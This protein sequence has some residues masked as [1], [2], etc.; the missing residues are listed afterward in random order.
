MSLAF[1]SYNM[2]ASSYG[3]NIIDFCIDVVFFIDIIV[4]FNTL[5]YSDKDMAYIGEKYI[6]IYI[7]M[8]IYYVC[9]HAY[10]YIHIY[11]YTYIIYIYKHNIYMYVCIYLCIYTYKYIQIYII[12]HYTGNRRFIAQKYCKSWFILDLASSLPFADFA[13]LVCIFCTYVRT[14]S[15]YE[16]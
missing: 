12:T 2:T 4:T 16:D 1:D 5:Y 7:Y 3:L 13:T 8:Y 11:I 10:I 6:R 15:D 9:I 14:I